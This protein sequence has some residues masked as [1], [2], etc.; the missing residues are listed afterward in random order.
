[1]VGMATRKI[2]V[3]RSGYLYFLLSEWHQNIAQLCPWIGSSCRASSLWDHNCIFCV[4]QMPYTFSPVRLSVTSWRTA[5][6]TGLLTKA[7]YW[8]HAPY[9]R[10]MAAKDS[11]GRPSC[12]P[13]L[14]QNEAPQYPF[15]H[16][17]HEATS[18]LFCK[19]FTLRSPDWHL[20]GV[21][22]C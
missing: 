16:E 21:C 3:Y 2:C 7:F 9:L 13:R 6:F 12:R 14:N 20:C 4:F 10:P 5:W 11:N 18:L 19:T 8:S 22:K 1:M 15:H 17:E